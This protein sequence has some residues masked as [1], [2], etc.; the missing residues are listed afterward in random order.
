MR[1]NSDKRCNMV[2]SRFHIPSSSSIVIIRLYFIISHITRNI[3][4]IRNRRNTRKINCAPCVYAKVFLD[5]N[6]EKPQK[7]KAL[8]VVWSPSCILVHIV[9]RLLS[10]NGFGSSSGKT[11]HPLPD[12][13]C[14]CLSIGVNRECAASNARYSL[15]PGSF[16]RFFSTC[17]SI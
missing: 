12:G 4:Y 13:A 8:P 16:I 1:R 15:P 14:M 2:Y 11:V 5:L 9:Y 17:T 7:K 6:I 3:K 10:V